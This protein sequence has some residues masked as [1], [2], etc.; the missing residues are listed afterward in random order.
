MDYLIEWHWF[1]FTIEIPKGTTKLNY[2]EMQIF[3]HKGMK[4]HTI[5]NIPIMIY[6]K[7]KRVRYE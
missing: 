7:I 4:P 3:R 6:P 1:C 2:N 5:I